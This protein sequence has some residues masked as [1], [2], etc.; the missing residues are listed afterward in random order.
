MSFIKD[1]DPLRRQSTHSFFTAPPRFLASFS[2][3]S[4]ALDLTTKN[5]VPPGSQLAY[6]EEIS[7]DS[8]K[9]PNS[10]RLRRNKTEKG[11]LQGLMHTMNEPR[12]EGSGGDKILGRFERASVWMVNEGKSFF[13]GG[14]Q[15]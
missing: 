15:S 11:R 8:D 10:S 13:L 2:R 9:P 3:L 5:N 4:S 1:R 12:E 14:E 6:M 7:L